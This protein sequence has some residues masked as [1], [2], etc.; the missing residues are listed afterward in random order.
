[1]GLTFN[2]GKIFFLEDLKI[3]SKSL[4]KIKFFQVKSDILYTKSSFWNQ[5]RAK[6]YFVWDSSILNNGNIFLS[7]NR[8]FSKLLEK[9]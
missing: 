2:A 7:E 9:I 8:K 5:N 6:A 1:M 3:L 4:E